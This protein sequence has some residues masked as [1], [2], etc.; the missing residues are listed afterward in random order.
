MES[1]KKTIEMVKKGHGVV[2]N[3]PE[4]ILFLSFPNYERHFGGASAVSSFLL[5][6][7]RSIKWSTLGVLRYQM[8]A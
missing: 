7:E 3:S 8:R 5:R 4:V 6:K 1:I 2:V